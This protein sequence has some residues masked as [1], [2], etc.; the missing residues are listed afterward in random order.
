MW[1]STTVPISPART[2]ACGRPELESV[3]VRIKGMGCFGDIAVNRGGSAP[4]SIGQ[5]HLAALRLD[6]PLHLADAP[7]CGRR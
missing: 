3:A 7:V 6:R 1:R 2:R 4:V 5:H